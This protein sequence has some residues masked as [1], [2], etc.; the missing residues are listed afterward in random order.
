[1]LFFRSGS[2]AVFSFVERAV[3]EDSLCKRSRKASIPSVG[4]GV[5]GRGGRGWTPSFG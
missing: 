1:M 4:S 2:V 5:N 3:C